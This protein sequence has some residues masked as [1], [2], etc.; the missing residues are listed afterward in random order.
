VGRFPEAEEMKCIICHGENIQVT[1]AREE[2]KIGNDI[3]YVLIRIPVCDDCGE[4]YYDRRTIRYLE[5][6]EKRLKSG[7]ANLHEV[8][9]ILVFN[10]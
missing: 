3:V 5:E 2:L 10:E 8:G 6:V 7:K 1:K 9:K 4:R